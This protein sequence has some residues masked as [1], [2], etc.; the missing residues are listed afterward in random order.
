MNM[1]E[2]LGTEE[3]AQR[4]RMCRRNAARV[5]VKLPHVRLGRRLFIERE[6]LVNYLSRSQRSGDPRALETPRA[7]FDEVMRIV[8][9]EIAKARGA[10]R[11]AAVQD[12][13]DRIKYLTMRIPEG[14]A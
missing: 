11:L 10:A 1:S 4:L 8:K 3:V 7:V 2:M 12:V 13:R 5:M 9:D 6:T 14:D